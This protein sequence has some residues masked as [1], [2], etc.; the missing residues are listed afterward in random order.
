MTKNQIDFQNLQETKRANLAREAQG[1][2]QLDIQQQTADENVRHNVVSEKEVN[3]HNL[4]N[5]DQTEQN[6]QISR[7]RL[8]EDTRHN[9][10]TESMTQQQINEVQRHNIAQEN[11]AG[12]G[13]VIAAQ[14]ATTNRINAQASML[15]AQTNRGNMLIQQY[16]APFETSS[17]Y[18][19]QLLNE[20][21]TSES[22]SKQQLNN[23]QAGQVY[24]S[25]N[26]TRAE[27]SKVL[28]EKENIESN[29]N[30]NKLKALTEGAKFL[31]ETTN[32]TENLLNFV[33]GK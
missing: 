9:R 22:A 6:L 4:I 27:T 31:N 26:K 25:T 12:Y 13:N 24:E 23:A 7:D 21:R 29:T 5:E 19:Q 28:A 2:R 11:I 16:K 15:N 30:L 14:N 20:Q 17:L 33:F 8:A 18:S 3:R 32:A 10:S 1:L